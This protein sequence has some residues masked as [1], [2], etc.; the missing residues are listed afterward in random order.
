[1][2]EELAATSKLLLASDFDGT[3]AEIVEDPIATPLARSKAALE[4][5]ADSPAT[6]VAVGSC[7]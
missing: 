6:T 2:N 7:S 1:M 5:L 3:L 4:T